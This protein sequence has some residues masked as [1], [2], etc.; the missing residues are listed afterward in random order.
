MD[1]PDLTFFRSVPWCAA[2]I[3]DPL[4]KITPTLARQPKS[5]TEDELWAVTLKTAQ[6]FPHCLS[7]SAS[8]SS[9]SPS[10]KPY[11]SS[12]RMLIS[13]GAG[14][15]G[16]PD[17]CHGGI[18]ATILDD[19]MGF[20]LVLN[21]ALSGGEM[22]NRKTSTVSLN[23]RFLQPVKTPNIIRVDASIKEVKG[24]KHFCEAIIRDH[25]GVKMAEADA[26]WI[27]HR[28]EEPKL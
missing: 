15:N 3:N 11:I 17:V 1:D 27:A 5:S 2:L 24:R 19:S 13:L 23:V 21:A 25:E 22:E 9:P 14:L 8:P 10:Q 20:L 16:H 4:Y 7:F 28:V 6:T 26:L 12:L 18:L